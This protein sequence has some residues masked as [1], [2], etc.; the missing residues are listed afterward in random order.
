MFDKVK[1]KV[2][3][4][5]ELRLTTGTKE[6]NTEMDSRLQSVGLSHGSN[7]CIVMRQRGGTELLIV[8][9]F[10]IW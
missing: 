5:D 9:G 1:E 6:L 3:A 8:T 4:G 2:N 10:I 7:V